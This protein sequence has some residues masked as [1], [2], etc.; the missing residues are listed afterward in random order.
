MPALAVTLSKLK[1]YCEENGSFDLFI[2]DSRV[3]LSF[4]PTFPEA[5][6]KGISFPP[7]VTMTGSVSSEKVQFHHVEIEDKSGQRIRD[8]DEAELVYSTWLDFIEENY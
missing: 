3:L 6:E 4:V 2:Q 1:K 5:G 8:Q 7:K